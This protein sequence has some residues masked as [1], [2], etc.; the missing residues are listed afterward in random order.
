MVDE[1]ANLI[2]LALQHITVYVPF[3]EVI[4]PIYLAKSSLMGHVSSDIALDPNINPQTKLLKL[5]KLV[6]LRVLCSCMRCTHFTTYSKDIRKINFNC[7]ELDTSEQAIKDQ[8]GSQVLAGL[9]EFA[10]TRSKINNIHCKVKS[11]NLEVAFNMPRDCDVI[12]HAP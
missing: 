4:R 8:N 2:C 9:M 6:K 1:E 11:V 12:D 5:K 10:P 3:G 7:Q